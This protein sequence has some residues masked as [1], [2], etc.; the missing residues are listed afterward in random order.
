V[1][2]PVFGGRVSLE[3]LELRGGDTGLQANRQARLKDVAITQV[4]PGGVGLEVLEATTTMSGG[5]VE[6]SAGAFSAG[7]R[8]AGTSTG[9]D[10][11]RAVLHGGI[12]IEA[13]GGTGVE[14]AE[15]KSADLERVEIRGAET[16][17]SASGVVALRSTLIADSTTTGILVGP[18]PGAQVAVDFTTVANNAVAGI[19]SQ[20]TDPAALQV[21]YSIVWANG[22]DLKDLATCDQVFSSDVENPDCTLGGNPNMNARITPDFV[23][24]TNPDPMLRDYRLAGGSMLADHPVASLPSSAYAGT[25]CRD[26]AGQLRLADVDGD[27][28]ANGDPGAYES[29][30]AVPVPGEVTGTSYEDS[31]TIIWD[32]EPSAASYDVFRGLA[33]PGESLEY[34]LSMILLQSGV[35][36]TMLT[37][38]DEPPP[39]WLYYYVIQ[40]LDGLG[41]MGTLGNADCAERS[42]PDLCGGP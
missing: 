37:D 29:P 13:P 2:N 39:G 20:N 26:A 41:N 18:E 15:G 17:M 3:N 32:L 31:Q 34:C 4:A 7:V 5:R 40:A 14:V 23:D 24:G 21:S 35:T 33:G 27:G 12:P 10:A 8:V 42:R 36:G 30:R 22:L 19:D 16:G 25:P 6:V 38:T 9:P 1:Q 28:R 11:A